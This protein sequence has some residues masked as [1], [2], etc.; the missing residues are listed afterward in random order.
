MTNTTNKILLFDIE[1]LPDVAAVWKAYE[2]Y[3]P[4]KM[5]LR[6]G[7]IACAAW[8]WYG[9][10]EVYSVSLL[11]SLKRFKKNVYDDYH[12]VRTLH[13]VLSQADVIVAQNGDKFDI[14]W[15]N[16]QA[17]KHGLS[18]IPT[19][20]TID[21]YKVLK[22]HFRFRSNRLDYVCKTLGL[23]NKLETD[24]SIWMTIIDDRISYTEK[25]DALAY[26]VKY[27]KQ[28]IRL[29]EGLFDIMTPYISNMPALISGDTSILRC[30][31]VTCNSANLRQK[32][33]RTT[34]AGTQY[35]RYQC[36]DC[37]KWMQ[38]KKL[39]NKTLLKSM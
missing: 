3:I 26:L 6:E 14:K 20:P 17:L 22:K 34:R 32:G 25:A 13:G 4:T 8:K 15:Y 36:N 1:T 24:I 19:I 39:T 9:T 23:G 29:L 5:L 11:G 37:G 28:D 21:T 18:P 35:K 31:N 2:T 33:Y 38:D 12:V 16:T 10:D 27:C 30:I 7:S